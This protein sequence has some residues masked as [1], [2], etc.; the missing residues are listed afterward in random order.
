MTARRISVA[1]TVARLRELTSK[2]PLPQFA[3]VLHAN[4]LMME[5]AHEQMIDASPDKIATEMPQSP[6][7][8][9]MLAAWLQ[10]TLAQP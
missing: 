2:Q 7:Y 8:F 4:H 3:V 6:A 10:K 9:M 1:P 5:L